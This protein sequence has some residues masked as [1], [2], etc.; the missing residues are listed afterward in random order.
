[1]L[2][3]RGA[4]R[5]IERILDT[6]HLA[7]A[8]S[9]LP[10]EVLHRLIESYGLEDCSELI[11]RSTPQQLA[12]VLDLDLW[13]RRRPGQDEQLDA[14]RFGVWLHTLLESGVE[15]AAE[16]LVGLDPDLAIAALA[17]HLAVFEL[18]AIAPRVDGEAVDMPPRQAALSCE[19]GG[20]LIEARRADAWDAILGLLVHLDA[21]RPD[22]FRR[23]MHGCRRLSNSAPELDGLDDLVT[24]N[25]QR[26]FDVAIDREERRDQQGYVTPAQARAFLESARRL[27]V[28]GPAPPANPVAAAYFRVIDGTARRGGAPSGDRRRLEVASDQPSRSRADDSLDQL[29]HL[30]DHTGLLSAQPR[31]L[32]PAAREERPSLAHIH[33]Q[34]A[35]TA[36]KDPL[37][38]SR[39]TEEFGFL[40][41]AVA[42]GCTVQGR[43]FTPAEATAAVAA[44]CNLG[45]EN[46]PA[47]WR[48]EHRSDDILGRGDL[49]AVFQV[50]WTV[51]HEQ[52]SMYVAGRLLDILADVRHGSGEVQA[53]FD[54]LRQALA[55]QW[56]RGSPWQARDALDVLLMLDHVAWA[57]LLG[58][59]DEC[60]VVHGAMTAARAATRAID[61][62]SFDFVSENRQIAAIREYMEELAA[63][64]RV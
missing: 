47:R 25:E 60:P 58:L 48:D 63:V 7:D 8:I 22:D 27:R 28:D 44:T 53:G 39:R 54:R 64:L 38:Y 16:K 23:M 5:R 18:A 42:T 34:M 41:N 61:P 59:M 13:R 19:I 4:D 35:H 9:R 15:V 1:V 51:L 56:R 49:L 31:A 26:L 29:L 57:V 45:L 55:R 2:R 12:R 52:V 14:E 40:A 36:E 6:P 11:A 10:A 43:A 30:L 46:W 37:A 33:A 20:Y 21:E 50:G 32:L 24:D 3:P 62:S 17:Q